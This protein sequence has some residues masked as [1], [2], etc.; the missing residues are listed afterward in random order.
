MAG[1][2]KHAHL[3]LL[4]EREKVLFLFAYCACAKRSPSE[5]GMVVKKAVVACLL[6]HLV[7]QKAA[8]ADL[9]DGGDVLVLT[10]D[11]YHLLST[12]EW[13]VEL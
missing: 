9:S 11:N 13:M 6:L 12:G 1:K 5:G 3:R 8:R 7:L 10:G 4:I 2:E